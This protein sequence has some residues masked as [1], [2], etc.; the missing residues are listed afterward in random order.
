LTTKFIF[1]RLLF[2][3]LAVFFTFPGQVE[4]LCGNGINA[5]SE[6]S[7]ESSERYQDGVPPR[8]SVR[9]V[10]FEG[11]ETYPAMVLREIIATE[12]PGF[13]RKL[14]F[15]KK[16]GFEYAENEVRRDVIRIRNF[17][18]RRGFHDARVQYDVS[19][20][21]KEHFRHVTFLITEN[22]P[23]RIDSIHIQI[24]ADS[25]T[26]SDISG[27]RSYNRALRRNPPQ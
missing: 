5:P 11:N 18:N 24:D 8:P 3:L 9:K 16:E 21:R 6:V 10:R 27:E 1:R 19:T 7:N 20:G 13:F 17:Y 2:A 26:K 4:P 23:L 12:A 25:L 15:W 14:L 22:E